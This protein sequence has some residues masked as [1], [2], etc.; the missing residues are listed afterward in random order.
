MTTTQMSESMNE[1]FY[2]Y[3]HS[4][5][6]LK[7]FVDQYDNALC[8]KVEN[9][10]LVDFNSFNVTISCVSEFPFEMQFQKLYT[11]EKYKEVQK[12]IRDVLY[13]SNSLLKVK[14][15]LVYIK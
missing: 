13:C 15:E 1:F 3:V 2:G 12:E 6:S 8:T 14:V 9:E 4:S 11:H 5:T 7:E 10:N